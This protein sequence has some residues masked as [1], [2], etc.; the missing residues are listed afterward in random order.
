MNLGQVSQTS[1]TQN[2]PEIIVKDENGHETTKAL[3]ETAAFH[4]VGYSPTKDQLIIEL[5]NKSSDYSY[6]KG[7]VLVVP[8]SRFDDLLKKKPFGVYRSQTPKVTTT[9]V[10]KPRPY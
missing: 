7:D 4:L 2:I 5:D 8:A 9:E 6:S 3:N 10:K 1:E